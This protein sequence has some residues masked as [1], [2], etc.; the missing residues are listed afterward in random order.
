MR[1]SCRT[2]SLSLAFAEGL[3]TVRDARRGLTG[4]LR[5]SAPTVLASP[6]FAR[7][8]TAFA[9]THPGI[10]LEIDLEDRAIDPV[11]AQVD[12]A[13][14]IGDPGDDPRLARKLFTTRGVVC[15][16]PAVA[17]TITDPGQLAALT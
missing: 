12:L 17:A 5:I 13:L 8:V 11:A 15:C 9:A 1:P 14:R 10:A 4:R 6:A 7:V 3:D 16:A 2:R